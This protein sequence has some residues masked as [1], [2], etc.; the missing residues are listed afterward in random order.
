MTVTLP[1]AQDAAPPV[2]LYYD[3]VNPR[4]LGLVPREART[5]VEIGCGAGALATAYRRFNPFAQWI[6]VETHAEAAAIAS[7]RGLRVISADAE[8]LDLALL[9]LQPRSVDCFIYGDVLE[10]MVDPWSVVKRH[11]EYL[12]PNGMMLASIPNVQHWTLIR[13]VLRGQWNYQ[14]E[15]LLDRTHLRFF[16]LDQIAAMF[17]GAG[18]VVHDIR[19][20]P[21]TGEEFDPFI[22][23]LGPALSHLGV[24]AE[25]FKRRASA[26][27]FI[28]RAGRARMPSLLV[29]N[30]IPWL[31]GACNDVRIREP[32]NCFETV[33]GIRV[34]YQD[35]DK[36]GMS[37]QSDSGDKVAIVQRRVL[38]WDRMRPSIR[39][40]IEAGYVL[41]SEM[42][43]HPDYHR[44]FRDNQYLNYRGVHGNQTTTEKLAEWFRTLNPQVAVFPNHMNELPPPRPR[45]DGREVVLFFG[46]M[47]RERDWA[48]LMG[49]INRVI[50]T[51]PHVRVKVVH[52]RKFFDALDIDAARKEFTPNTT[53]ET[54]RSVLGTADVSLMPLEDN[55]FN[56]NKSD[57]KFIEAA[58]HGAAA[59][60][61]PVVYEGTIEPGRTGIIYHSP[62]AF[63]HELSTLIDDDDRRHAIADAAYAY[64]RERRLLSR[65]FRARL[66]WYRAL[67]ADRTRL[68]A[69]LRKRV[70]EIWE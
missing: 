46:A 27:Q 13:D 40:M 70:P 62:D 28:V 36:A 56:R 52:D 26:I 67:C 69:E 45:G 25:N 19:R 38:Y 68:T 18:L 24:D 29:H 37:P 21:N 57:L 20:A 31:H 23:S 14:D 11:A 2:P 44:S 16:G 7:Q 17:R 5:I 60:A 41:V 55:P 53:Y 10:H 51:R 58:A 48:P 35:I 30:V 34:V 4:L 59:L 15:G 43:D 47:N 12:S 50:Q 65:H 33:P 32:A 66:D 6:G 1:P 49:A 64:V 63:E 9:G 3:R 54:Y 22:E 61:S 39:A 42:D 8:T